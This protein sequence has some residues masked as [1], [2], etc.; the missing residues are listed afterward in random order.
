MSAFRSVPFL[1]FPIALIVAVS[2]APAYAEGRDELIKVRIEASAPGVDLAARDTAIARAKRDLVVRLLQTELA[3][4]DLSALEPILDRADSYIQATQLCRHETAQN[5]TEVEIECHLKRK[6][7]L[8]DTATFL[9]PRMT[10]PPTV[11]VLIAE[12]IGADAP[13]SVAQPGTAENTLIEKLRERGFAIVDSALV[14]ACCTESDLIRAAQ[15]DV[16]VAAALAR[17]SFADIAVFGEAQ[18]EAVSKKMGSNVLANEAKVTLHILRA[19]DGELIEAMARNARVHSVDAIEGAQAAFKDVCAKLTKDVTTAA[20]LSVLSAVRREGITTVTLEE[21]GTRSR[22][23]L[24]L[25]ALGQETAGVPIEELFFSE[26]L[27]RVRVPYAGSLG[28][29]MKTVTAG[30]YEGLALDPVKAVEGTIVLRF[31]SPPS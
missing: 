26:T 18:C 21:P 1:T 23:D 29:L 30:L 27:A 9:F 14:R 4:K 19:A 16:P 11:F 15:G 5:T 10:S 2:G 7:L 12:R 13:L 6:Q 24:F 25:E 3:V 31:I 22:F 17:K 20:V 28:A 8:Q